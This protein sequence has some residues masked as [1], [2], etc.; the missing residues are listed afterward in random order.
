MTKTLND[1]LIK[2]SAIV[3]IS[4]KISLLQRKILNFLIAFAYIDLKEKESFTIELKYLKAIVGFNSKNLSYLK[5]ALKGLL[6]T[7]VEFNLLWKDKDAWSATTLLASVEFVQWKCT[8]SFSP[9]LRKKLHEPN[10]YAKIKLSTMKLFSSKY[11]LC[12]YEIFVDYQNIWQTPVIQLD[13]FKKLMGVDKEKYKEFKRFSS[14]VIK[15]AI[16]ELSSIGGYDVKITY[17]KN[18]KTVTAIKFNF[19]ELKCEKKPMQEMK[20]FNNLDLQKRLVDEFWLSLRQAQK[21]IK[22]YPIPYINESLGIIKHKVHQ[23]LIK[24]I[25][26]YSLTV[27]KND[28][29]PT[30][31]HPQK[32]S[33]LPSPQRDTWEKCT[34]KNRLEDSQSATSLNLLHR[35]NDS[36]VSKAQKKALKDF[37]LLKQ[38]WQEKLIEEFKHDKISSDIL[39]TIY[40][41]EGIEGTLIKT[42]FVSWLEKKEDKASFI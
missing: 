7:I 23:K 29:H 10:I 18:N 22:T 41:K 39:Q 28:F 31:S 15:P 17:T 9:V 13:D 5:E 3:A 27:L 12:L 42:M 38:E 1:K 26:A 35:T 40:K 34:N 32:Q 33:V 16:E 30:L 37:Y 21:V 8:Y 24:N 25:P 2:N 4:N 14:R 19:K 6:A 11:S 20:I 36:A